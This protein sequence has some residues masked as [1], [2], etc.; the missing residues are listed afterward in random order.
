MLPLA[1]PYVSRPHSTNQ[2]VV[3]GK[4]PFILFIF[5]GPFAR[6]L[7]TLMLLS[8]PSVYHSGQVLH[9]K[10]FEHLVWSNTP[11]FQFCGPHT[12]TNFLSALCG[13][14]T[15]VWGAQNAHPMQDIL[16]VRSLS[17]SLSLYDSGTHFWVTFESL[18]GG[19]LGVTF[20]SPL[21]H[22][23]SFW[24]SVEL[25][26]RWLPNSKWPRHS[27]ARKTQQGNKKTKEKRRT[28]PYVMTP[29]STDIRYLFRLA[30]PWK[31][32]KINRKHSKWPRSFAARKPHTHTRETKRV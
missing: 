31:F 17:L 19:A 12:R 26:A 25:G 1:A 27:A 28:G 6:T 16:L 24:V 21:G 5:M 11:G 2:K 13:L 20:K 18:W 15:Q 22:F 8:W 9:S 3:Q 14:P 29:F 23:N 32:W 7:S 30:N 4:C 10:V